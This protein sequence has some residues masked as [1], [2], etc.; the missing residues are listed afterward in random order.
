VELRIE[1]VHRDREQTLGDCPEASVTY[2]FALS[3]WPLKAHAE[4]ILTEAG[5]QETSR[6]VIR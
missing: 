4:V 5:G 6:Q 2:T 3:Y 1:L